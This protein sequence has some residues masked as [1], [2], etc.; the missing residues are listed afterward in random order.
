MTTEQ[1]KAIA[2]RF[3]E[4]FETNDQVALMELFAPDVVGH[5][6]G[7]PGP[8][9]REAMLQGIDMFN[10]AFSEFHQTVEDQIAEGDRVAT[11]TTA[12]AVHTGDFQGLPA[13]GKQIAI[14]AITIERVKD[15]RIVEHWASY[16]RLGL[17][18][19]LGVIPT[20]A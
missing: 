5:V 17:M 20:T 16:D 14:S 11:R 8:Q 10:A 7:A 4:A 6:S 19:Q 2:R 12:R 18:Q 9:S 15:G 13:T 1:N 3:F